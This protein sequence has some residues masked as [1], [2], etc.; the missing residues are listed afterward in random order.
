[1][2]FVPSGRCRQHTAA[3]PAH[4][5]CLFPAAGKDW[6]DTWCHILY[7]PIDVEIFLPLT[8]NDIFI[9]IYATV[10]TVYPMIYFGST[11]IKN[12]YLCYPLED[13]SPILFRQFSKCFQ[14][15]GTKVHQKICFP[16]LDG[17]YS[18]ALDIIFIYIICTYVSYPN[19][20]SLML[21][22]LA[23]QSGSE[24]RLPQKVVDQ[25]FLHWK[26]Q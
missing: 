6:Q 2:R 14:T 7:I 17:E 9:D 26:L 5:M 24:N 21:V 18:C 22:I 20:C 23:I 25:N 19:S 4:G 8:S 16:N 15:C 1:M 3:P 10:L 13:L 12:R 11:P